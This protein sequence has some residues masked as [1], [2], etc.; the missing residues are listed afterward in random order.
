MLAWEIESLSVSRRR[1][2]RGADANM[3]IV[4]VFYCLIAS[5][6]GDVFVSVFVSLILKSKIF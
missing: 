4:V 5:F 6:F 1:T 2:T 3:R